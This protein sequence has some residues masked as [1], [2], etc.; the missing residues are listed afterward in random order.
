MK[1]SLIVP[2]CNEEG[3]VTRFFEA[4]ESVFAREGFEYEYIF[5][6]DG[7]RDGTLSEL[8]A[9]SG[10][11]N[12]N[13]RVISFSRNFGKESAIYAG[14]KAAAGEYTTLIDADLQQ[15]P[16]VALQMVRILDEKPEI[17]CVAAFQDRRKESK[18]LIWFKNM[19]YRVIN[20]MTTIPFTNAA[21]DFRTFRAPVR[22]AILGLCEYHRFSKGIFSWVGFETEYIPYEVMERT[23]GKS[24]W[25]FFK[26]CKYA[27]EGIVGYTTAPLRLPVWLG[28]A[29]AAGG[30]IYFIVALI[31]R[32]CGVPWHKAAVLL[33][34]VAFMGGCILTAIGVLGE[35]LAKTYE[36]GKGRPLYIVRETFEKERDENK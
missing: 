27:I 7:S 18:L 10:T 11:A 23:A 25:S 6:N 17:D 13:L 33:A 28:G 32:L 26:L 20:G 21:S 8:K 36:Q 35:Y 34:F 24:K 12:A 9:L 14:M 4:A 16:E 30:A 3:N 5:V 29:S 15:R 19:F 22:E 2:C 31:R 1:L